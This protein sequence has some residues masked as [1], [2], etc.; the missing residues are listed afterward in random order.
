MNRSLVLSLLTPLTLLVLL[1]A[2]VGATTILLH[3]DLDCAQADGGVGTCAMGG[4][5]TGILDMTLDT[6]VNQ[7]SWV[8]SW[9][10]ISTL[11]LLAHFHGPGTPSQNVGVEIDLSGSGDL[12]FGSVRSNVSLVQ[13][14][15]DD[16]LAGLWY[17]NIHTIAF[18]GGEI[19][20][21]ITVVPEPGVLGLALLAASGFALRWA[22]PDA[23]P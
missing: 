12:N 11:V 21:H 1:A 7:I 15:V 8:G 22:R 4:T 14:Q 17:V 16:L 18:N 23:K 9:S 13:Q 10:G 3:A 19:R 6:S 2:P 20:G 5:G